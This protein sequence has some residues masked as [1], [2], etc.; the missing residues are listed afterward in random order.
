MLQSCIAGVRMVSACFVYVLRLRSIGL[1]SIHQNLII[2]NQPRWADYITKLQSDWEEFIL[3]VSISR[4][5]HYSTTYTSNFTGD[6]ITERQRDIIGHTECWSRGASS[7]HGRICQLPLDHHIYREYH[8]WLV[9]A[10]E[11]QDQTAGLHGSSRELSNLVPLNPTPPLTAF[12][13]SVIGQVPQ[14]PSRCL[15]A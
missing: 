4:S 12:D 3:Y 1:E 6:H 11:L 9:V 13:F 15:W 5:L 7:H 10:S 2:R 14:S 8:Y